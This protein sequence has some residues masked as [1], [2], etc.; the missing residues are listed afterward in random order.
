ME[1][2]PASD[3]CPLVVRRRL[4]CIY[5]RLVPVPD[6]TG[7][8][9]SDL[10][11]ANNGR[12][13]RICMLLPTCVPASFSIVTSQAYNCD[14]EIGANNKHPWHKLQLYDS[15]HHHSALLAINLDE[16]TSNIWLDSAP[17]LYKPSSKL[18]LVSI[19]K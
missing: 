18:T 6:C 16:Y 13:P 14:A 2:R 11:L 1:I 17:H 15:P 12:S 7:R 3:V 8:A 4:M 9:C 5:V 19:V 10:Q